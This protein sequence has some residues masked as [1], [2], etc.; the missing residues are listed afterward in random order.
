M[1]RE[2]GKANCTNPYYL[3]LALVDILSDARNQQTYTLQEVSLQPICS[4]KRRAMDLDAMNDNEAIRKEGRALEWEKCRLAPTE[5]HL[6]SKPS[7]LQSSSPP[8][9]TH[10][11]MTQRRAYVS[12]ESSL[13]YQAQGRE[14]D[15]YIAP[16]TAWWSNNRF[17]IQESNQFRVWHSYECCTAVTM[18]LWLKNSC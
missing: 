16:V 1:L 11:T 14:R 17:D 5:S 2:C 12:A 8:E 13:T 6:L 10:D 18:V 7:R 9:M 3:T 15:W 4:Y